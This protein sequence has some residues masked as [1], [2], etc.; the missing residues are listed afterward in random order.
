MRVRISQTLSTPRHSTHTYLLRNH[1]GGKLSIIIIYNDGGSGVIHLEWRPQ[2]GR[3]DDSPA[4]DRRP[5]AHD[6][7]RNSKRKP[8][9]RTIVYGKQNN[10]STAQHTASKRLCFDW[11]QTEHSMFCV[12]FSFPRFWMGQACFYLPRVHTEVEDSR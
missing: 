4:R 9:K 11:G 12:G 2:Y 1:R 5:Q 8:S 3:Q 6:T 10:K 7:L